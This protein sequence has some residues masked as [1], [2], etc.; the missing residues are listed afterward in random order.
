MIGLLDLVSDLG[1]FRAILHSPLGKEQRN[2]LTTDKEKAATKEIFK[3]HSSVSFPS[4]LCVYEF[5]S[6][7]KE[8]AYSIEHG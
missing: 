8:I 5:F 1:W 4:M 2:R 3:R 6:T 7:A